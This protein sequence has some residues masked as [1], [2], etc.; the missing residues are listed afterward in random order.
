[1]EAEQAAETDLRELMARFGTDVY[2]TCFVYLADAH[3][4]EDAMQE[5]F[6]KAW[7]ARGSFR[8]QAGEKT[9]LTRI[10]INTCKDMRR[11]VWFRHVERK[12]SLDDLPEAQTPPLLADDT[13]INAVMALPGKYKSVILLTYYW[14]MSAK[15]AAKALRIAVPTVYLRLKTARQKLKAELEGWYQDE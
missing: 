13:L 7:R 9:W 4:A 2:R 11:G 12:V 3:L 10:A 5:T 1:M 8:G 15:E 14:G 6:L